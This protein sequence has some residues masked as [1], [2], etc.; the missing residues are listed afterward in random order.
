MNNKPFYRAFLNQMSVFFL[1]VFAI[2]GCKK[3]AVK[4]DGPPLINSVSYL[5]D[6]SNALPSVNYGEWILIKGENLRT[7]FKVD[8]NTI[9]AA[10]SLIYAGDSLRIF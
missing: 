5:T 7:T 6:R 8:F 2:T 1:A 4:L 3:E 10:D 9:L